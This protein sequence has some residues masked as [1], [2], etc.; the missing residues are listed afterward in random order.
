MSG[1]SVCVRLQAR[2]RWQTVAIGTLLWL[3]LGVVISGLLALVTSTSGAFAYGGLALVLVSVGWTLGPLKT[4]MAWSEGALMS[5]Q[6]NAYSGNTADRPSGWKAMAVPVCAF[7]AG[8]LLLVAAA[9]IVA[10]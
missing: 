3:G 8:A 6:G 10:T 4:P 1:Q 9:V 7:V 2:A 5:Y